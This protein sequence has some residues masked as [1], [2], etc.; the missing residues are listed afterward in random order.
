MVKKIFIGVVVVALF[1]AATLWA[2]NKFSG[3][4]KTQGPALA[5]LPPLKAETSPSTVIAP[6]AIALSAIR[7][8]LD[9]AAPR[10]F[11]GKN[12]N[13][14]TQLGKAEIGITV[15]R[16]P[17]SV[18]GRAEGLTITTPLT[19]SVHVTGQLGTAAGKSVSGLSGALGNLLGGNVGKQLETLANKPFDQR[20]EI[21]GNVVMNSKP[22]L[23]SAWR[24]EPNLGAQINLGDTGINVAG[25]K[26]NLANE[27]K[28]LLDPLI[29]NQVA[30]LQDRLRNDPVIEAAARREWAKMCRS[31]PLGG[32]KTGLPALWLEFKPTKAFAAQP[33]IDGKDVTLTIGVQSD[34]RIVPSETKPN[35]PFPAQLDIVPSIDQGRL[36]FAVPIDLPFTE[37]NKLLDA[38]LKGQK[39]PKDAGASPVVVEVRQATVG[40]AGERLLISLRVKA[41]ERKSWFGFGAEATVH[42]WGKPVLDQKQQILRLTDLTLAVESEAAF[43]LLGAAARAAVPQL[44]KALADNAV[45]DL[46]PFTADERAKIS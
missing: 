27:I 31:I 29:N 19:G 5:A 39:F 11:A 40:A 43:G 8:S 33:K 35:C 26:L 22:A 44:E 20:T 1:F 45:V 6:V 13:P 21:K 15:G 41:N 14:I 7:S 37:V 12:D 38:Q 23:T 3:G 46:K 34:T 42:I 10:E 4:G 32:G 18:S 2:L 16:G 36:S 17:L 9:A 24:L 30:A 25:I 28:P